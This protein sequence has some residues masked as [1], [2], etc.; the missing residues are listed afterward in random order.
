LDEE[1]LDHQ[2]ATIRRHTQTVN[3]ESNRSRDFRKL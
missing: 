1:R 2:T 3:G